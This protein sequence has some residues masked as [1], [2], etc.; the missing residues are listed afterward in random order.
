MFR[1]KKAR[2]VARI[3]NQALIVWMVACMVLQGPAMSVV[4]AQ[5]NAPI[6]PDGRTNTSVVTNGAVTDVRTGSINGV[7]A[8]NSF[9][10]F[11]VPG[12]T[13]TNLHVPDAA[14]NLVNLVHNERSEINGILNSYRNG[15]IGGNVYFLNPHGIVIG[16]GGVVNV[17]SL[18][19]MTPTKQYMDDLISS[20][21]A[22]SMVHERQ[23]FEGNV[24]LGDSGVIS[25]KGKVNAIESV[26]LAA[27][28]VGIDAGARVR[29]GNQVRVEFDDIVS[30]KGLNAG[31]D[32][33][34]S[35]EG[36]ISIVATK[37]VNV[38][39]TVATDG[40]SGQK[41]GNV[42][43]KAG[44]D[45][46]LAKG[47][48]VSAKGVGEK[49]DG[50]NVVIFAD[51]NSY[52]ENGGLVDVS[53]GKSGDGG[54]VE[55]SAKGTVDMKGFGLRANAV[56]GKAGNI[57]IDPD[58]IIW[59]D[60]SKNV[61]TDGANYTLQA[62]SLIELTN[63]TISTR[64]TDFNNN[65]NYH[66][67]NLTLTAPN[68]VLT[69]SKLLTYTNA[70]NMVAG[71][72]T[73]TG[74]NVELKNTILDASAVTAGKA[75]N[76][77]I[78]LIHNTDSL[79]IEFGSFASSSFKMDKT[80]T[81]KGNDVGIYVIATTKELNDYD[82]D[83]MSQN[84]A[85]DFGDY[86]GRMFNDI[87]AGA[88]ESV[89]GLI[90]P[91]G[92]DKRAS[93]LI[94][95]DGTIEAAGKV[96]INAL[97]KSESR[98]S[99][100]G[101][102]L[103][104]V[105]IRN[106]AKSV[107]TIGSNAKITSNG[108]KAGTK[109][110]DGTYS[111]ADGVSIL[112]RV[113]SYVGVTTVEGDMFLRVV[114]A[115]IA[116]A[117]IITDLQN[118]VNINKN[119]SITSAVDIVVKAETERTTRLNISGGSES[120]EL[121]IAV[122]VLYENSATN[123]N[124]D[125]V[126]TAKR[127]ILLNAET[128]VPDNQLVVRMVKG[129]NALSRVN[130]DL[131]KSPFGVLQKSVLGSLF[132][133]TGSEV[134]GDEFF[135]FSITGAI[136]LRFDDVQTHVQIGENAR[137]TCGERIDVK[138]K[139]INQVLATTQAINHL[140]S[141]V[142]TFVP[143][144]DGDY[145]IEQK[146][147]SPE[148]RDVG[149]TLSIPLLF[150][151]NATTSV[152]QSGAQ[153][154]TNT[155]VNVSADTA[156]TYSVKHPL[157]ELF[158]RPDLFVPEDLLSIM[159]RNFGLDEGFFNTFSQAA[160]YN[161]ASQDLMLT[162]TILNLDNQT[163]AQIC[164]GVT[165]GPSAMSPSAR[166]KLNVT[167][168]TTTELVRFVGTIE[169]LLQ[170]I[171]TPTADGRAHSLMPILTGLATDSS[172]ITF[173][174]SFVSNTTIAQVDGASLTVGDLV[175]NAATK[176]ID[177]GI[178][179]SATTPLVSGVSAAV[180][181]L[182]Y[183]SYTLAK[184]DDAAKVEAANVG[185]LAD[186]VLYRVSA[187]G[188]FFG[189]SLK[190][191][192]LISGVIE[193]EPHYY[194]E[195]AFGIS[196]SLGNISRQS[197]A[198]WGNL[199]DSQ[200]TYL[201]IQDK[202]ETKASD[203]PESTVTGV[204][205]IKA[206]CGGL[207]IS[208]AMAAVRA[209]N[210]FKSERFTVVKNPFRDA[211]LQAMSSKNTLTNVTDRFAYT[212]EVFTLLHKAEDLNVSETTRRYMEFE[213]K[214]KNINAPTFGVAGGVAVNILNENVS[215][216]ISGKVKLTAGSVKVN[217]ENWNVDV[218]ATG[219]LS[220]F[221]PQTADSVLRSYD[222]K[223]GSSTSMTGTISVN[224]LV[225]E[226]HAYIDLEDKTQTLKTDSLE[227][228]SLRDGKI[229]AVAGG[230]S[231]A[232]GN[233][234]S[235]SFGGSMSFSTILD[236]TSTR[237]KNVTLTGNKTT[238][239]DSTVKAT[240]NAL[241]VNIGGGL[242]IGGSTSIGASIAVSN[243][244]LN[245]HTDIV[246]SAIAGRNM[247]IKTLNNSGIV[248][249]ALGAAVATSG[250]TDAGSGTVAAVFSNGTTNLSIDS[251][252][253]INLSGSFI[254]EAL[255]QACLGAGGYYRGVTEVVQNEE[256]KGNANDG[257][258]T[259]FS[260][261]GATL[262]TK[263]DA[264]N[265]SVNDT[266]VTI[267]F[268]Q[269]ARSAKIVTAALAVAVADD[270]AIGANIGLNVLT[271]ATTLNISGAT[272]K[273][274]GAAR[275]DA[276]T[277]GGI[278]S[279]ALGFAGSSKKAAVSGNVGVNLIG[280]QTAVSIKNSTVTAGGQL[281]SKAFSS[282]GIIGIAV[283]VAISGKSAGSAS[284]AYNQVAHGALVKVD[285]SNLSGGNVELLAEN[286][287]DII[288]ALVSVAGGGGGA[289][290][291]A[292]LAINTLGSL[293]GNSES[294]D[295]DSMKNRESKADEQKLVTDLTTDFGAKNLF[296]RVTDSINV[297]GVEVNN[298]T[299]NTTAASAGNIVLGAQNTGGIIS[300]AIGA[301]FGGSSAGV[302]AA[303]SYNN[304]ASAAHV[305]GTNSTFTATTGAMNAD[306]KIGNRIIAVAV[307][308]A[309][310]AKVAVG[311][312]ISTNLL[313][314]N[315][316]VQFLTSAVSARSAKLNTYNEGDII[317]IAGGGAGAGNVGVGIGLGV[318]L[319][320]NKTISKFGSGSIN[321][322]NGNFDVKA[323]GANM[324]IAVAAA[325]GVGEY[326]GIAGSVSTN[327]IKSVVE[328]EVFD[329]PSN[330]LGKSSSVS[331]NANVLAA[332]TGKILAVGGSFS[333]G[334]AAIAG[335]V[336]YNEISN[337]TKANVDLV[338]LTV[339]GTLVID[340]N[341]IDKWIK[342]VVVAAGAGGGALAIANASNI[343]NGT[344]TA[345]LAQSV[346]KAKGLDQKARSNAESLAVTVAAAMGSNG[347]GASPIVVHVWNQKVLAT[348]WQST[349]DIGGNV[350]ISAT[351]TK[352]TYSTVAG[353]AV[354]GTV[355]VAGSVAVIHSSGEATV[356][357]DNSRYPAQNRLTAT[358]NLTLK[359]NN[360]NTI[361][362]FVGSLGGAQSV[363]V[364]VSVAVN[365]VDQKTAVI[366]NS[367]VKSTGGD[368]AFKANS[369][370]DFTNTAGSLGGGIGV[371]GAAAS[372]GF[373]SLN[374]DTS[375]DLKGTIEAKNDVILDAEAKLKT[376]EK[377]GVFALGSLAVAGGMEILV[378]SNAAKINSIAKITAGRDILVRAHLNRDVDSMTIAAAV[379]LEGALAATGSIVLLG[380][381]ANP[382]QK[383]FAKGTLTMLNRILTDAE[384]DEKSEA[385]VNKNKV[386]DD[387]LT[388]SRESSAL[389]SLAGSLN[390]ART[391][392][393]GHDGRGAS[394]SNK[395]TSFA[396]GAGV[397]KT[398]GIGAGISV[399]TV[400]DHVESILGGS[401]IGKNIYLGS[402]ANQDLNSQAAAGG[403]GL[404]GLGA[405]FSSI[406]LNGSN[407][408]RIAAGSL[409][410]AE[411][412]DV[413]AVQT[414]DIVSN[415]DA[416]SAGG[417][418]LNGAVSNIY[419][420]SNSV[421]NVGSG[422]KIYADAV[423][424]NVL[425]DY[426]KLN[427][428]A[429]GISGGLIAGSMT[430]SL[431]AT[432]AL[433]VTSNDSGVTKLVTSGNAGSRAAITVGDNALFDSFL[434]YFS[435]LIQPHESNRVSFSA[436]NRFA[437][438]D[439]NIKLISAGAVGGG[440]GTAAAKLDSMT[441]ISLG[442]NI[443]MRTGAIKLTADQQINRVLVFINEDE[444]EWITSRA[445]ALCDVASLVGV[446]NVNSYF[447]VT[448][449]NTITVGNQSKLEAWGDFI[450]L[451]TG[452]GDIYYGAY[453][454]TANNS[455]V[456]ISG[457]P[458][459]DVS[460]K[461][462]DNITIGS[463]I[464]KS[465]GNISLSTG[466]GEREIVG[467]SEAT[468]FYLNVVGG[469]VSFLTGQDVAYS[470]TGGGIKANQVLD[471]I[472]LNG[473]TLEAGFRNNFWLNVAADG[474]ITSTDGFLYEI[475]KNV[476][477]AE[478]FQLLISER[479]VQLAVLKQDPV[480]NAA[481]IA[482]MEVEISFL[483]AQKP[484]YANATPVDYLRFTG[485]MSVRSGD[486]RFNTGALTLNGGSVTANTGTS[487]SVENSSPMGIIFDNYVTW[488]LGTGGGRIYLSG[489]LL[490][491]QADIAKYNRIG[492]GVGSG[493]AF[494][495]TAKVNFSCDLSIKNNYVGTSGGS[496]IS[497]EIYMNSGKFDAKRI[498][499][500]SAGS[501]WTGGNF[502]LNSDY[503]SL[504]TGGTFMQ[505]YYNGLRSITT[506]YN[507]KITDLERLQREFVSGLP[508]HVWYL[509][510]VA[511]TIWRLEEAI[512]EGKLT[513]YAFQ[514][515]GDL[516]PNDEVR[517]HDV[518]D[519][520]DIDE[521]FQL[522]FDWDF[523]KRDTYADP[524]IS[525]WPSNI[526]A[527]N[528]VF[529]SAKELN[530]N[531]TIQSGRA[532]YLI[533][534]DK[535]IVVDTIYN[536][537]HQSDKSVDVLDLSPVIFGAGG[538]EA[539]AKVTFSRNANTITLEDVVVKGG[540]IT[541]FGNIISTGSGK[542]SV[543]DGVGN[544]RITAPSEYKLNLR[545]IDT[546]T[547]TDGII[548]ITD[549]SKV[550][551]DAQ[552][553][554][555]LTTEY[556]RKFDLSD[557]STKMI[558]TT[559]QNPS[560]PLIIEAASTEYTPTANTWILN[561]VVNGQVELQL[562][563][564][565][566]NPRSGYDY[567]VGLRWLFENHGGVLSHFSD[568]PEL[569][570][571]FILDFLKYKG[572][573]NDLIDGEGLGFDEHHHNVPLDL[574]Y[575]LPERWATHGD[576]HNNSNMYVTF[577]DLGTTSTSVVI[578]DFGG[579]MNNNWAITEFVRK[580]SGDVIANNLPSSKEVVPYIT[581]LLTLDKRSTY[582]NASRPIEVEFTGNINPES[583]SIDIKSRGTVTLRDLIQSA[584]K[585]SIDVTG[586]LM[587]NRQANTEN[588]GRIIGENVTLKAGGI[589][590]GRYGGDVRNSKLLLESPVNATTLKAQS[591]NDLFID[592]VGN[593][594]VV[595]S[596][597]S[598]G[599]LINFVSSGEI[600]LK[601]DGEG[602]RSKTTLNVNAESGG[603]L[604]VLG[605]P[606]SNMKVKST[607]NWFII[608]NAGGDI[609]VEHDGD[610]YVNSITAGG[611][612]R[613]KI[614]NGSL[615]D[616]NYNEEPDMF[617][618]AERRGFW[619]DLGLLSDSTNP[620]VYA[621]RD[622][623]LTK[624]YTS[625]KTTEFYSIVDMN[626]HGTATYDQNYVFKFTAEEQS[627]LLALGWTQAK[628][629]NAAGRLTTLYR[630]DTNIKVL[631]DKPWNEMLRHY[632][633]DATGDAA[634]A[635]M[636]ARRP[637]EIQATNVLPANLFLQLANA[638][639]RQNTTSMIEATNIKG[640]NV[641]ITVSGAIGK[642]VNETVTIS[643]IADLFPGDSA[644]NNEKTAA[645][646]R[647]RALAD[648][649]MDD[650]TLTK[651]GQGQITKF[652][653]NRYDD[654]DVEAAGTF[655]AKSG[656]G[657][658]N[659][660]SQGSLVIDNT[661][662]P[663]V[664]AGMNGDQQVRL[665]VDGSI[666]SILSG[667]SNVAIKAKNVVLE[668]A[669]GTIG[670]DK[671]NPMTLTLTGTVAGSTIDAWLTARGAEGV[672][673]D[674]PVNLYV[675]EAGSIN[676]DVWLRANQIFS[677]YQYYVDAPVGAVIGGKNISL[678]ATAGDIGKF[679]TGTDADFG[680]TANWLNIVPAFDGTISIGATNNVYVKSPNA[681]LNIVDIVVGGD[682]YTMATD[683]LFLGTLDETVTVGG[684]IKIK[685]GKYLNQLW[686]SNTPTTGDVILNG[687]L[688]LGGEFYASVGRDLIF[689]GAVDAATTTFNLKI[690]RDFI[691]HGDFTIQNFNAVLSNGRSV[692]F[693][694][695]LNL[696]ASNIDA[697]L[698]FIVKGNVSSTVSAITILTNQSGG[699]IVIEGSVSGNGM[700]IAAPNSDVVLAGDIDLVS[701]F[702]V[703][704]S[705]SLSVGNVK[706]KT[707]DMNST[708]DVI[709][710]G[711]VHHTGAANL[712]FSIKS[713]EGAIIDG[714]DANGVAKLNIKAD[715]ASR[716][717]VLTAATGIG[718]GNPLEMNV[719]LVSVNLTGNGDIMLSNVGN[720]D[721]QNLS[722]QN[723]SI[724]VESVT[725]ILNVVGDIY[726]GGDEKTIRLAAG[727]TVQLGTGATLTAAKTISFIAGEGNIANFENNTFV[728]R[729]VY[730]EARQGNINVDAFVDKMSL[731]AG[732]YVRARKTNAGTFEL[733]VV[734][735]GGDISLSSVGDLL[736][737]DLIGQGKIELGGVN[738][739]TGSIQADGAARLIA[740]KDVLVNGSLNAADLYSEGENIEIGNLGVSG[741]FHI[742]ATK[743]ILL[744]NIVGG[745]IDLSGANVTLGTIDTDG[746]VNAVASGALTLGDILNANAVD[747][748]GTDVVLGA[749]KVVTTARVSAS[750]DLLIEDL[751]DIGS[752]VT[753]TTENDLF[754]Y[755]LL[756]SGGMAVNLTA[757]NGQIFDGND[758][759]DVPTLNV[760]ASN[761]LLTLEAGFGVGSGNPL[762]LNVQTVSVNLT[763]K[764]DIMLS[765]V[766]DLSV[767][768]LYTADGSIDIESQ[769][770]TLLA[771][772]VTALGT[773]KTIRL[774]GQTISM[775]EGAK[776]TA[777]KK[778]SYIVVDGD[779]S[780][781]ATDFFNTHEVSL[782]TKN[783]NIAIDT[784]VNKMSLI[785]GGYVQA[786][787]T[788]AGNF[789]L[790]VVSAG[791]DISLSSMGDLLTGDLTGLGKIDLDGV[792]ITT[793][794]IQVDG[795]ATIV[796]SKDVHVKGSID[797][798]SLDLS[799]EKIETGNLKIDEAIEIIATKDLL[800]GNVVG[801]ARIDLDGLNVRTGSI[802]VVGVAELLAS[803]DLFVV[804]ALKAA[805]LNL[806]AGNNIT[807]SSGEIA[808]NVEIISTSGDARMGGAWTVG[809]SL[810][811]KAAKTFGVNGNVSVAENAMIKATDMSL[812]GLL[813]AKMV[814][815][816]AVGDIMLES[817]TASEFVK[818][819]GKNIYVSG[820][821]TADT[822]KVNA[823]SGVS[824]MTVKLARD[825]QIV[826]GSDIR[827]VQGWTGRS[828]D[829]R[830][831]KGI[832]VTG[833]IVLTTLAK[834][835]AGNDIKVVGMIGA[836]TLDFQAGRDFL[837]TGRIVAATNADISA[838]NELRIG[839][840]LT[841][842]TGLNLFAGK[843]IYLNELITVHAG[844]VR[845]T[846]ETGAVRD[847]ND[848]MGMPVLNLVAKNSDLDV[849]AAL[850]IGDADAV[851]VDV[852]S[853]ALTVTKTGNIAVAAE[854]DVLVSEVRA[855]NGSIDLE[856]FTGTLTVHNVTASGTDKTIRLAGNNIAA[857]GG[858]IAGNV[859]M[860]STSGD[861]RM[862]G[863]WTVGGSVDLKAAKTVE[864]SG[865]ASVAGN[866]T[867]KAADMNLGGLLSAKAVDLTATGDITL[868]SLTASEFVKAV[869]KNVYI[870]G[871]LTANTL[872]VNAT[873]G[874]SLMTVN[875][876][877]DAQI[878]AGNDIRLVQGW[879]GRSIDLRAGNEIAIMGDVVLAVL[880]KAVA[881]GDIKIVGT[882]ETG[883]RDFQAGGNL[884]QPGQI[885]AEKNSD[886]V[887]TSASG[888]GAG[889]AIE[890]DV[891][892][893]APT[894]TETGNVAV[895]AGGDVRVSE[896]RTNS[897]SIDLES[898]TGA[899]QPENNGLSI[900]NP[901]VIVLPS[902]DPESAPRLNS[903]PTWLYGYYP[904][905]RHPHSRQ[906]HDKLGLAK[907]NELKLLERLYGNS[908]LDYLLDYEFEAEGLE[909]D[910]AIVPILN[911]REGERDSRKTSESE[912]ATELDHLMTFVPSL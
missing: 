730:L 876:A 722:T 625:G 444:T 489:N 702:K 172:G 566:R 602:F 316:N 705:K 18:T 318:N 660:G 679:K 153:L 698:N 771:R 852:K 812:S 133:F 618:D 164:D 74:Q 639:T 107:V 174:G 48:N 662:G 627:A 905:W 498:N 610:M 564:R 266:N 903:R 72:I 889:N 31:N 256:A 769:T 509:G 456:P 199:L 389:I 310:G 910:P 76:V 802:D 402:Y 279:V 832:A 295:G 284:I 399:V 701:L 62:D 473:A 36:K 493:T 204:V 608:L 422:A 715:D 513:S 530:I 352:K 505:G 397:G 820:T 121:G 56:L 721:L 900:T 163:V 766:G 506:T 162:A 822:L 490:S 841:T 77:L 603:I 775:Y 202:Q 887:V 348:Q 415:A 784:S 459:A 362:N 811:L 865:N 616:D 851:E 909:L 611:N 872:K 6:V 744:G 648:A 135:D 10:R 526:S 871:T 26:N 581:C 680:D 83:T 840:P 532:D 8:Y 756:K 666:Y 546:G 37:S 261:S 363:G 367:V 827:L 175:V 723:G 158:A 357:L 195:S 269:G 478:Y 270:V 720:L 210:A 406:T 642:G 273:A 717:V 263:D 783:G 465:V 883:T 328:A 27:G 839:G 796:A 567:E 454:N 535:Q 335:A 5:T 353:V 474:T 636:L 547:G 60:S 764:G 288:S 242:S 87:L 911:E 690:R 789:E 684:T 621:Q 544:I 472:T 748:Q 258:S 556:R 70:A 116:F 391:I 643:S 366:V 817:L 253:S 696:R 808:G 613:L 542:L 311:G 376:R 560:S 54:F 550:F 649:E 57:L 17:G 262:E 521:Q 381:T 196:L 250:G 572:Y 293:S 672:Y 326:A 125:G 640:N 344:I 290:V 200:G 486:V 63:V 191:T 737:G 518:N 117:F 181:M 825:A 30:T 168:N 600:S 280:G 142:F 710:N 692:I 443:S 765:S 206:E 652:T 370:I 320:R 124:V 229:I 90:I 464:L 412:M 780:N 868:E 703:F 349:V 160:S 854:R 650:V 439:V 584:G 414:V 448:Q 383:E 41:A 525:F 4:L 180:T 334:G 728:T 22:V 255:S 895:T 829:L 590:G 2:R 340:A 481:A 222:K 350:E 683:N 906:Y 457:A 306:S 856:S 695:N 150:V 873:N 437:P 21:G 91:T 356:N 35:P 761:A 645:K 623:N 346:V 450:D 341:D 286:K 469:I 86:I 315:N 106:E 516:L 844:A 606:N 583:A 833:D 644:T 491:S 549:T 403:A 205:D 322:T 283:N 230:A 712:A 460:Y 167:A 42:E 485:N 38:T 445:L 278:I 810:N 614:T 502:S 88:F 265:N 374:D 68:I 657:W 404:L 575:F 312:G 19:M 494:T 896:V 118:T 842:G 536:F 752:D 661:N 757:T 126:L 440:V 838:R 767:L 313:A 904:D 254:A 588:S 857:S 552:G 787:K 785:A 496:S 407:T 499:I 416:L 29:A 691:V 522:Q 741:T 540:S 149:M 559:N 742:D 682:F 843:D 325:G 631:T 700:Q 271:D 360:S 726:A 806:H 619:Q 630:S 716:S 393:V 773:D 141:N 321:T 594:L 65:S 671:A 504:K 476:V 571:S 178:V 475:I 647:L 289:G 800:L 901:S 296:D 420:L 831:G 555:F 553:S 492:A 912:E 268:A 246:N 713:T 361:E 234:E 215:A 333:A 245:T 81:I 114:P 317:A 458:P 390:A 413:D 73:I 632:G 16:S 846:A 427:S 884:I 364:G 32:I 171:P 453:A 487:I 479:E 515:S 375:I 282:A 875:L 426:R 292:S 192:A 408:S 314:A 664:V 281:H 830:A 591:G 891:K 224:I 185:I 869:G 586:D 803:N 866:T 176:A 527:R 729:E 466:A 772:N 343:F 15:A 203:V 425:N 285:G 146:S 157:Y 708:G 641:S 433:N 570:A 848:T 818:A 753:L 211:Y 94:D 136:A 587:A 129:A 654:V 131:F 533:D 336:A 184:V 908:V 267:D 392:D 592:Y 774:A 239:N 53:A 548:A 419:L 880:A 188:D 395:V 669:T 461:R 537:V 770:G 484:H 309:G 511:Y 3:L 897:G 870:N 110:A 813:S 539:I 411:V 686:S 538:S 332:F 46:T 503:L 71:S 697:G 665:K 276:A 387:I 699:S 577:P 794:T 159:N 302:G 248:T 377:L 122:G 299:V 388:K 14:K 681:S 798:T 139:T 447:D 145:T 689:K 186:D 886:Q 755:A 401:L 449:N 675:R 96:T 646:N 821:L 543:E 134:L 574:S 207:D 25:V 95:I 148:V 668:A 298:S 369:L 111:G 257:K 814:D 294:K 462:T 100:T 103:T 252:T 508:S 166:P 819:V 323:T 595:D 482:A 523:L 714:N 477:P 417:V 93:A 75:G 44:E 61:Y 747:L 342:S 687:D 379:G 327:I 127:N 216:G 84:A 670:L 358:G 115:D 143:N 154:K 793:G 881:G 287:G 347:S 874:V 495:S 816:I 638:G 236:N 676:G 791:D 69:N 319:I 888:I 130:L 790:G 656:S 228:N 98:L 892:S 580:F 45:I 725:G 651:N 85:N 601:Q 545:K 128:D 531:G 807:T 20:S 562:L 685:A 244:Q 677:A 436:V 9:S 750:N 709:L 308:G 373:A 177:I 220:T 735:A 864:I 673:L 860:V 898:L 745:W 758:V 799:A 653:I 221:S 626:K 706:T 264:E 272:I 451:T 488:T 198:V 190:T 573:F 781:F 628:L 519:M 240:N 237:M 510:D 777:D 719:T 301:G 435:P 863:A 855:N 112:S 55:F 795:A 467:K 182:D 241:I 34:V 429:F 138:A 173:L 197:H 517:Y 441:E 579:D 609:N 804:G 809:G 743:D 225:G 47:A 557:G 853:L 297:T 78:D 782:E 430:N 66:S 213:N 740:S 849:T 259:Y 23:L 724:D 409:V 305:W 826:A 859:V 568:Q 232:N 558:V 208:A 497:S 119:A 805:S 801:G 688:D 877:R 738:I 260:E 67:G 667:T 40:V 156:I 193:A 637:S 598:T 113:E 754:L 418:A 585:V 693:Q 165:I 797:A 596:V 108:T 214:K 194:P 704:G 529:I 365:T 137:L 144:V 291:G 837:Q 612:V 847:G 378:V 483:N 768:D 52:L 788:N 424:F 58:R 446:V 329:L 330:F 104:A 251:G 428:T 398:G 209:T 24:P 834:A 218:S 147:F 674:M 277:E 823:A 351:D 867:I 123:L 300:I 275:F 249:V 659:I 678:T 442:K 380:G 620:D 59:A 749:A 593:S 79:G 169:S 861:V 732:G 187:A 569:Q 815:L 12:G 786:R 605:D 727:K 850:G 434:A 622:A 371:A 151:D 739:T 307:G 589:I 885:A 551:T 201:S 792:N 386:A 161:L 512:T 500:D 219:G 707:I 400:N 561:N 731:V 878:V 324:I 582:I 64:R 384:T 438:V 183:D 109:N 233:D 359:A 565:T 734:S 501:I 751:W 541:L 105:G 274:G 132:K 902:V 520:Y 247:T 337:T 524:G 824:L 102:L 528:A 893:F 736:T 339:G 13:T 760:D 33:V 405:A 155:Q 762:E 382:D 7:N 471:S 899:L 345:Q 890:V 39:G 304:I 836:E 235:A 663:G 80:S 231:I 120:G 452:G 372:L 101:L 97:A 189:E 99:N 718:T 711:L 1:S 563:E 243:L 480:K 212:S 368:V 455:L 28:S 394:A 385:Y 578:R 635:D 759:G 599:G 607:D 470:I 43:I 828:V 845:F 49:S 468:N 303:F 746:T 92:R 779:L 338:N 894:G 862:G 633:Y 355:G 882:L 331:G 50:G 658:I 615:F 879:T 423:D 776:L 11:N 226:T 223:H 554:H 694:K 170:R 858:E 835:V 463:A 238:T 507:D 733:G 82:K 431:I 179:T 51:R 140:K 152:V 907:Y 655:Q 534:M 604:G 629:D 227:L 89:T 396:L 421:I 354:A 778:I 634:L 617:S 217:A 597:V 624:T 514:S 432:Q 763:N 576:N 410:L